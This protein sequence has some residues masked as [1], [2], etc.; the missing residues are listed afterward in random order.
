MSSRILSHGSFKAQVK[1]PNPWLSVATDSPGPC[2]ATGVCPSS[3]LHC[4]SFACIL[5]GIVG[6]I[7]RLCLLHV[8]FGLAEYRL[9]HRCIKDSIRFLCIYE[10]SI[11]LIFLD[12][13]L[14]KREEHRAVHLWLVD[15]GCTSIWHHPLLVQVMVSSSGQITITTPTLE[16]PNGS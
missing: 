2:H 4:S 3:P 15:P 10:H 7:Y 9:E 6:C 13:A 5:E 1:S 12:C 14:Y 8:Q 16:Q 11:C